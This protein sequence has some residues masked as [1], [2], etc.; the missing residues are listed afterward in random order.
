MVL[1]I[2]MGKVYKPNGKYNRYEDIFQ[3]I[4]FFNDLIWIIFCCKI[5]LLIIQLYFKIRK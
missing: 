3:F 5:V 2:F 1:K 4:L